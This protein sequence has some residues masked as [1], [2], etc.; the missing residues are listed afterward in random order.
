MGLTEQVFEQHIYRISTARMD[1]VVMHSKQDIL[2]QYVSV[3]D[4]NNAIR[5]CKLCSPDKISAGQARQRFL[6]KD[7]MLE[8][9]QR[10]RM[11]PFFLS[12]LPPGNILNA[13]FNGSIPVIAASWKTL[14]MLQM[15]NM[16]LRARKGSQVYQKIQQTNKKALR[17]FG[18]KCDFGA[19]KGQF[20]RKI[21]RLQQRY[22]KNPDA[23]RNA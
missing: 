23:V 17:L 14:N 20:Q 1:C 18:V 4:R 11:D 2:V 16:H 21:K 5:K 13:L 19:K 12:M 3:E 22:L 7:I 8:L 15:P 6:E 10:I 9:C